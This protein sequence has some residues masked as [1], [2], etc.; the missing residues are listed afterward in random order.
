[1]HT[2]R[3]TEPIKGPHALAGCG[4]KEVD[5]FLTDDNGD[6][7]STRRETGKLITALATRNAPQFRVC[8]LANKSHTRLFLS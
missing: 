7:F 5:A 4:D 2:Y 3:A 6:E 1:M 8:R